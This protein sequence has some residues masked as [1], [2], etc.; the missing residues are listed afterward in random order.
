MVLFDNS[1]DRVV[2][3]QEA[4]SYS[5]KTHFEVELT[6]DSS[7][8]VLVEMHWIAKEYESTLSVLTSH[9]VSLNTQKYSPDN[10]YLLTL[11]KQKTKSE[12][13]SLVP[14]VNSSTSNNPKTSR[15]EK[16]RSSK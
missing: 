12:K 13:L 9:A 1:G 16:F 5:K 8:L 3:L 6:A 11:K 4:E 10:D 14:T 2:Y 15:S 7:Y